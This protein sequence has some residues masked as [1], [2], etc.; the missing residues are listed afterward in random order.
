MVAAASA[1]MPLEPIS[2]VIIIALGA[3]EHVGLSFCA[4]R[5]IKGTHGDADPVS[6]HGFPK[7]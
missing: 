3:D 6:V 2:Y 1:F 7:Q 5:P 4:G